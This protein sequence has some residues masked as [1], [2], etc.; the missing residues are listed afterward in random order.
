[1]KVLHWP[2]KSVICFCIKL[3]FGVKWIPK[4]PKQYCTPGIYTMKNEY[5]RT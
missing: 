2:F 5:K 1:M 3:E 4:Y